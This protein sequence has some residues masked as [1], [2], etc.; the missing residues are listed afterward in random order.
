MDVTKTMD[1]RGHDDAPLGIR[2]NNPGN[3]RPGDP[4][5]GKVGQNKGFVVFKSLQLGLRALAMD[6]VNKYL[7]GFDTIREVITRYAPEN[8]NNTEA[9]IQAVAASTGLDPEKPYQL[10]HENLVKLILAI[11]LHEN[12]KVVK[13]YISEPLVKNCITMMPLRLYKLLK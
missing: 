10:T 8:E 5:V 7:K 6:L 2:N 3:I 13:N 4:W 11:T 9:Y 1:Y 12:G